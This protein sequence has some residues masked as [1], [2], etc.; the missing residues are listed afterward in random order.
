[1]RDQQSELL[2]VSLQST[3]LVQESLVVSGDTATVTSTGGATQDD[4]VALALLWDDYK[5][6][7]G[8]IASFL[9]YKK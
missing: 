2:V 7:N 3:L 5:Y 8:D 9:N 6:L 4:I 1:M